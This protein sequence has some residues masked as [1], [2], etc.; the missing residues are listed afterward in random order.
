M[1]S[2]E[3]KYKST[4]RQAVDDSILRGGVPR[5]FPGSPEGKDQVSIERVLMHCL[6]TRP[7]EN[8]AQVSFFLSQEAMVFDMQHCWLGDFLATLDSVSKCLQVAAL[9]FMCLSLLSSARDLSQVALQCLNTYSHVLDSSH[10]FRKSVCWA[11]SCQSLLVCAPASYFLF[12]CVCRL[13]YDLA[14]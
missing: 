13:K 14:T 2:P 6:E 11:C 1:W 12:Y 10:S 8:V 7:F 4:D 3:Y 5:H 9:V